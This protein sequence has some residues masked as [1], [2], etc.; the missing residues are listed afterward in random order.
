MQLN[1]F[2]VAGFHTLADVQRVPLRC[3]TI[4]TGRNDSGKSSMLDGLY[5]LLEP[6]QFNP[7]RLRDHK[8]PG[9]CIDYLGGTNE[10]ESCPPSSSGP[11]WPASSAHAENVPPGNPRR[12][13]SLRQSGKTFSEE[14][15]NR[16]G[17]SKAA[18]DPDIQNNAS[19]E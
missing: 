6:S 7:D 8:V 18:Y 14:V 10:L 16:L 1:S 3:P 2:S 4:L 13:S 12:F 19:P 5:F 15:K 9:R 17:Q 11:A